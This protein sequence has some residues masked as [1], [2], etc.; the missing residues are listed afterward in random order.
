MP[1]QHSQ[2]AKNT[3]SQKHKAVLNPTARAA[4]DCT[5]SAHQMSENFDRGLPIEGEAPSRR[6]GVK[7]RRR[8][9]EAEDEEGE[10]SVEE[11]QSEETGV[12][13][14]SEAP[15]VPNLALSNQTLVSQAEPNFLKMMEHMTQLMGPLPQEVTPRDSFEDP[16]FKTP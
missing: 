11:E 16:A 3:R 5:P 8:L 13:G 14:A 10:E 1:V 7:A 6:G 12:A 2:P 9:G 15:E 4:L